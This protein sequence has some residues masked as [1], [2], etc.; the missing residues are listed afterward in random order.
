M[1]LSFLKYKHELS[2]SIWL[3]VLQGLN[4][5][6]PLLVWPYMILVL[7]AEGFGQIGFAV[8]LCQFLMLFVDFGFNLTAT[9]QIALCKEEKEAISRIFWDTL[10]AKL[11]LLLIAAVVLLIIVSIP[12]YTIYKA[13]SLILFS[14]VIGHTFSFL[15]LYQ[16]LGEIRKV[17]IITS[18]CRLGILPLVFVLVKDENDVLTAAWVQAS[19]YLA[20]GIVVVTATWLRRII[21]IPQGGLI[22]LR[23]IGQTL[24]NSAPIFLSTALSSVY[25]LLFV[26]ILGYFSS[27]IEVGKYTAVEKIMRGGTNLILMPVLQAFFPKVSQLGHTNPA[28]AKR[29]TGWILCGIMVMMGILCVVLYFFSDELMRIMGKSYE[30]I[31]PVYRIMAFVPLTIGLSGVLGQLGLIAQ[32]GKREKRQFCIVYAIAAIA[33]LV[34][35]FSVGADLDACHT[36]LSLLVAELLCGAGMT[37]YYTL[38]KIRKE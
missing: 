29:T 1:P 22:C 20:S 8:M 24:R 17:S 12:K 13:T 25:S 7:G 21:C 36:A 9:K 31:A 4:Y 26:V 14:M 2:D 30:G 11:L 10:F 37:I 35:I 18:I 32:G 6:A 23:T 28:S 16:G 38:F 19:T 27:P 15:W 33:S 5:L 3:F 34:M